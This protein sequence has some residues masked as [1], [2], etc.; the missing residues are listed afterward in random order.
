[1]SYNIE[2]QISALMMMIVIV[3]VFYSKKRYGSLENR[4]YGYMIIV[5]LLLVISDI[6][7]VITL[8]TPDKYPKLTSFLGYTYL[9]VMHLF[10]TCMC[11][12]TTAMNV[13]GKLRN[14]PRVTR[15][16]FWLWPSVEFIAIV[17][18]C[19]LDLYPMGYGRHVYTTG[20]AV[21][22]SYA[23]GAVAIVYM[24]MYALI[25]RKNIR[26]RQQ[27]PIYLYAAVEGFMVIMQNTNR[28]L[29]LSTF[30]TVIVMYIMYFTLE[31]PD[32]QMIEALNTAKVD[33]ENANR[34]K[35]MFLANMSHEIRTPINTIL[36]MDEMILRES[37]SEEVAEYAGNIK[38]AGKALLSI[39][40]DVLDFSKI[41]S[42]KMELVET[43][44]RILDSC[45]D[46]VN[47]MQMRASEKG[48]HFVVDMDS[49]MP[50]V[51]IGDEVRIR[52]IVMNLLT[53]AVKYTDEGEVVLDVR[54]TKISESAVCLCVEVRDTGRGILEEDIPKL[55]QSFQRI[56]EN[57]NRN[58]E[59]TGL[60]LTIV[61][62]LL[63]LM[64]SELRVQST[65]GKGSIFSFEIIQ[66]VVDWEPVGDIKNTISMQDA[67]EE[68]YI[69]APKATILV[70][71][72]NV[73]NLAVV[74]GLLKR[75]GVQLY[76]ASCGQET[77][78]LV[79]EH[80]FDIVFLDHMM[81]EMDGIETYREIRRM[82]NSGERLMTTKETPFL[83]L[84]A[85][86]VA[87]AK[88]MYLQEGFFDYISKPVDAKR[89]ETVLR[90]YLPKEYIEHRVERVQKSK[91]LNETDI[92]AQDP[93][94]LAAQADMTSY[95]M[96]MSERRKRQL[97]HSME[98]GNMT[99]I[100]LLC[101]DVR[102]NVQAMEGTEETQKFIAVLKDMEQMARRGEGEK[103]IGQ[104]TELM[105][106]WEKIELGAAV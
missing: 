3:I 6:S 32:L 98:K 16:F 45:S 87:G 21:S 15:F 62:N 69:W 50:R 4:L 52:Q 37:E 80:K 48:L 97:S 51:L 34:A 56:D 17:V 67:G 35:T 53:N 64:N 55:Y 11:M 8:A 91:V 19:C 13:K 42:G 104:Q 25:N 106:I 29:L 9:V 90:M 85:N 94:T 54:H 83:I 105:Q 30:A 65:Y 74:R 73:M 39:V 33:A 7:S 5:V 24:V 57:R 61:Q 99:E 26:L 46:M 12:Y 75:T 84:T 76:V 22:F 101:R 23:V 59:G 43:E 63:E 96:A 100:C 20:S 93:E 14:A 92:R 2:F 58:I 77:I 86:A 49:E 95:F 70:T 68:R 10:I 78:A 81:P 79:K 82:W 28:F 102:C 71:D 41:E 27:F 88:E 72:D 60:G 36:G 44:Y 47:L 38:R 18:T 31:N 89:L 66:K 103:L 1:M 40:N